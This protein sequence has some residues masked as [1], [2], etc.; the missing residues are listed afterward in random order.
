[1]YGWPKTTQKCRDDHKDGLGCSFHARK[2]N[3]IDSGTALANSLVEEL[4][5]TAVS[6]NLVY[7]IFIFFD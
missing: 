1:M 7:M 3:T 2:Q 6:E 5:I 4:V